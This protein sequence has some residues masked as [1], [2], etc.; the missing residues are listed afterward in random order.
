MGILFYLGLTSIY[1]Y[2]TYR[3]V[4]GILLYLGLTSS[5]YNYFTYREIMEI[6]LYLQGS[7]GNINL[8]YFKWKVANFSPKTKRLLRN[9]NLVSDHV[10]TKPK[11]VEYCS[12]Y[13]PLFSI[14][15]L[16]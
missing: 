7:Y 1:N 14:M 8:P 13:F 3:E 4:M 6:L 5:I 10:Y 16:S 12:L 11:T 15:S 9:K 2:F